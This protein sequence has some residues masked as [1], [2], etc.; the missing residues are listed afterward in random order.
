VRTL[1]RDPYKYTLTYK[2]DRGAKISLHFRLYE[3]VR[4]K[5]NYMIRANVLE[6]NNLGFFQGFDSWLPATV[7]TT[8]DFFRI[9]RL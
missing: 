7:L 3:V 1:I 2:V 4:L 8:S 5:S 9:K 6:S